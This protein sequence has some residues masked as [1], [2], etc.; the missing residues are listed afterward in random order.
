M[1]SPKTRAPTRP[2]TAKRRNA[3]PNSVNRLGICY[4]RA[5]FVDPPQFSQINGLPR[6]SAPNPCADQQRQAMEGLVEVFSKGAEHRRRDHESEVRDLHAKIGELIV[7]RDF[8]S[9]G[10]GR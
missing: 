5:R 4:S 6:R 9:R 1:L 10:S 7:K 3:K 2:G 8:L